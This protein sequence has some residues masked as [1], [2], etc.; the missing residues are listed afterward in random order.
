MQSHQTATRVEPLNKPVILSHGTITC[1]DIAASRPFYEEF[2]GLDVVRHSEGALQMRKGGYLVIVCV[3]TGDATSPVR[4]ANHW[5]LDL[6]SE[7]AVDRALELAHV[8]QE[9]YGIKKI[10]K[11]TKHHG[12]YAFYF[13][14]LDDN[15]WEFQYAGGGQLDG[16]G[17]YDKHFVRGDVV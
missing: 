6:E 3:Q 11:I 17:R 10:G 14:D 16:T 5:G 9:R 13:Q 7:A 4:R 1:R 8:H 2:L 15:F 12:T